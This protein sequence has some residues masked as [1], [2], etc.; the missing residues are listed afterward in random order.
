M[1]T[2]PTE[3]ARV[4]RKYPLH[5]RWSDED[6]AFVGSVDGLIDNCCHGS[7]PEKVIRQ[8]RDIAEDVVTYLM[9]S[10]K[11]LP[12][13]GKNPRDPDPAVIRNAMGI[14][15]SGFAELLGVSVRTLHKWE[16]RTSRPSGA[17]RALLK[18]AAASPEAVRKALHTTR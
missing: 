1:K 3:A 9:D 12:S 5:V 6:E 14:S 7:T 10:G 13:A 4:A 15:Q 11:V 18:V 16:Q 8:L 17:A 2:N